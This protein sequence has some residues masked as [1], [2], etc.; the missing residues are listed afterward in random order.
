VP[1]AGVSTNA[2]RVCSALGSMPAGGCMTAPV[3]VVPARVLSTW[4]ADTGIG[5]SRNFSV[6]VIFTAS[7][8]NDTTSPLPAPP[9]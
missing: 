6:Y 9:R 7:M 1:D 8:F 4:P 2:Q 5:D 3:T